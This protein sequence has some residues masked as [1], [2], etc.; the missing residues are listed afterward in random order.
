MRLL[1]TT[2]SFCLLGILSAQSFSTA[3]SIRGGLT[4]ERVWWDLNYYELSV[5]VDPETKTISG[6][7]MIKFTATKAGKRLQIDLQEPMKL[8]G[9]T[10]AGAALK[11]SHNGN[12]H[13]VDMPYTL[14]EGEQ[15]S[16]VVAFEGNPRVAVRAPWDGGIV[17]TEDANGKPWIANANQGIG[18]SVWW[19]AKDHPADEVDS[20]RMNVT[21]PKGLMD[22][23]NGQ[24]VSIKPEGRKKMTYSWEVKNPI[25][26][27]GVNI[28]IGDYA[29]WKET[30]QGEAGPLDMS[31][32]VLRDNKTKAMK[33]F[34]DAKLMMEAFE[35]WFG[36]YPFYEDGFKLVE[37][38]YLGMEHQSAVTYGNKYTKGYLGN[39]MSGSG[40]GLKFD[41]IIIHESGH[42]WFANNI[43]N[44]DVADMW[45]HEGF[46]SYSES[47]FLDYHH[48]K[49]SASKYIIGTRRGIRNDRPIQS[50]NRGVAHEGSGDMYYKGA[51][52]LHTLRTV[53]DNDEKWREI[54]R[55]L[56]KD[57][58]HQTVTSQQVFD[59]INERTASE[60]FAP[61]PFFKTYVQTTKIPVFTY[62]LKKGKL[63]YYWKN[64]VPG[65]KMPVDII[66]NG[67]MLRLNVTETPQTEKVGKKTKE[68][69]VRPDFYVRME[70]EVN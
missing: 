13:Y 50:P 8:T 55:G 19:P 9:A 66:V 37:V 16:I 64:V 63:T 47:L 68:I 32:Y 10:F 44:A 5:D 20:M 1:F 35:H 14:S 45:V 30:Y 26:D 39:D 42:E 23:S 62:Q 28:S 56:N 57:F 31:Y 43:T 40:E 48:G 70:E 34:K 38:P 25:N 69:E 24:L 67:K 6:E 49:E 12:A 58:R 52:M 18:A 65:F 3:D 4:P 60:N 46:T 59:Y 15:A 11:V 61:H 41:Y 54:L 36:P 29:F 21:V 33:H 2:F 22:V 7:N 17:W 27:Y 53:I 51:N